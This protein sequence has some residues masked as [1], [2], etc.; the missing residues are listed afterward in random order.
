MKKQKIKKLSE[1]NNF[2]LSKSSETKKDL[3]IKIT[4]EMT[5]N[6]I[7]E[8]MIED[9][10]EINE[11]TKREISERKNSKNFISKEDVEKEFGI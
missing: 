6:E 4:K 3:K 9:Q 7:I 5:F 8:N 11:T 1:T 10:M 2:S